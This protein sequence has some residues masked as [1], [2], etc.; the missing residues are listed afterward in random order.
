META[1]LNGLFDLVAAELDQATRLFQHELHAE[2]PFV[3]DLCNHVE[4]FR[5]K[6][7]RPALLLLIARA[8]GDVRPAH[9]VLA[10]VVEMVHLATLV[11]DDVLDEAELRRRAPT[12]SRRWGNESAVLLG[13]FLFSHAY[14]LCSTLQDQFASELIA[15]TAVRLT[16]GELIQVGRGH[17]FTLDE[18]E[19]YEIIDGK[20]ASLLGACGLLGARY[21]G[22]DEL[23]VARMSDFGLMLGKAFQIVDDVLD[24]L[25]DE[26]VAGKTLGR[27]LEKGKLTLP[28]IHCL[29][30][31]PR[32]QRAKMLD[33]LNNGFAAVAPDNGNGDHVQKIIALLREAGSFDY[34]RAAAEAHVRRA[35]EIV[36]ALPESRARDSLAA[37]TE[38]VL[39]RR[40]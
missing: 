1:H 9:H 26:R 27:D 5:G 40:G 11:H 29:R 8:C 28:L 38:F 14:R 13:D 3:R 17:D 35:R 23:T 21:A 4:R 2:H 39:D 37:L 7:L 32:P 16:V 33:L 6:Q 19:Y 24:L 22:A 12:V 31:G 30:R 34:A 20:T 25:G 18:T 10:A 36:A 15:A